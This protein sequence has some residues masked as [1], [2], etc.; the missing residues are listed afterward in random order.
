MTPEPNP[1]RAIAQLMCETTE[2]VL[3]PKYRDQ[4]RQT[5]SRARLECRPGS[6][7]ATYHRYDHRHQHHLITYGTRMVMAKHDAQTAANWLSAREIRSRGYF[8][9]ELSVLN[10]LAH[11]C[12]HEFAHLL[13]QHGGKRFH[14][15]V[16]NHHFYQQL[17]QLNRNGL[18]GQVRD[19]LARA[20]GRQ[21][22]WLD[23][24]AMRLPSQRQQAGQW[25]PGD[26]VRFGRGASAREGQVLRVNRK[27]C[28]VEGTGASCG[29]RFRVP[30]VMLE[31][32]G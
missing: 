2:Q 18:A 32:L 14:G 6:G 4:L 5:R 31:A 22:L 19:Y 26:P 13:Q 23:D 11:T 21:K 29:L 7:R 17:D 27:T 16:H 9:G 30:F 3:W 15:S 20:A 12:N 10:L 8:G 24:R 25:Q 1:Y 28:T